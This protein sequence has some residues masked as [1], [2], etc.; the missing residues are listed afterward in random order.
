MKDIS[1]KHVF[2]RIHRL[3]GEITIP[4]IKIAVQIFLN[5]KIFFYTGLICDNQNI[6][7]RITI[8][9]ICLFTLLCY[10]KKV[11]EFL[12]VFHNLCVIFHTAEETFVVHL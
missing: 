7:I 8:T 1:I 10:R 5:E 11:S 2:Y 12:R 4:K 6:R 9:H 3:S